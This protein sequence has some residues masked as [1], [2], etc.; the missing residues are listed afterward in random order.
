MET[1]PSLEAL[2][3]AGDSIGPFFLVRELGNGSFARVFLA[4]QTNLE[5]RLVVLK[6]ST[7]M[8]REP[9]LL[10]R[11]RHA[12]IVEIVS[13]ATVDDG[14]FHL[15]CMPF[16]GG[17]TLASVLADV[18][19][20]GRRPAAGNDLLDALD[21]VA[22]AEFPTGQTAG[23]AREILARQS[24]N[25]A[26]AWL[27]ARLAEALDYAFSRAVAHGDVKPSNII[28]SANASPL[29]LDFN[30]ARDASPAGLSH[31]SGDQ[32]GTFAYMA[33]ERLRAIETYEPGRHDASPVARSAG[34]GSEWRSSFGSSPS[35]QRVEGENQGSAH[36]SDIYSLGMVLLELLTGRHSEPALASPLPLPPTSAL[37]GEKAGRNERALSRDR[38]AK[39]LIRKSEAE[40]WGRIPPGLGAILQ[41]CLSPDPS[42]RYGRGLELAIDL[43]R[44]RSD[45]PPVYASE[46]FWGETIPRLMRRQ[47]RTL[48]TA[49]VAFVVIVVMGALALVNSHE[50]LRAIG[51]RKLRRIWDDP[52][53][54]AVRFQRLEAPRLLALDA[55]RIETAARALKEY[56]LLDPSDWRNREDVRSL[57]RLDRDD[58]E[59]WLVEQVYLYCRVLEARPDSPDH[60]RR[61]LDILGHVGGGAPVP[62][63]AGLERRLRVRLGMAEA[64]SSPAMAGQLAARESSWVNEYLL[65][66]MAECELPSDQG[67][68]TTAAARSTV[69][70][71]K[72]PGARDA[73][74]ATRLAAERALEHYHRFLELHPD[75]FWGHYR[76][77]A[78]AFGL[79]MRDRIARA[80]DHLDRC[81][82]RRPDNPTLH[83]HLAACLVKLDRNLEAQREVETAI[84]RAPD[85]AE[86]YR[87]R[88]NI[89][90]NLRQTNGLADD[91]RH[92]EL[93]AHRL[94]R[95]SWDAACDDYEQSRQPSAVRA[96]LFQGTFDLVARLGGPTTEPGRDGYVAGAEPGDFEARAGLATAFARP[97]NLTWPKSSSPSFSSSSPITSACA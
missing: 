17:A 7:R 19:A 61:A 54:R 63:F 90:S 49:A 96:S 28:L 25:Q 68:L 16:L 89:R 88:T 57:S 11:V 9:W 10:A 18:R 79:G 44:W 78:V 86:F 77:A 66:V 62:A 46:P 75:S 91:V 32:G 36:Q 52:E 1:K 34:L 5:N 83:H 3:N 26:V 69:G 67:Q 56:E 92:F 47:K 53:S 40:G 50:T 20:R 22:A 31:A 14:A 51:N 27:V 94:P 12:H 41:R 74:D 45:R 2:P 59:I 58:L 35:V 81:L 84:E 87:T 6:V 24:Y 48:A 21:G 97:G 29:L 39:D 73:G 43:D 15:I 60:W 30:L 38:S 82:K 55:S 64:I 42:G 70:S 13:H 8:T 93:L 72:G 65:G 76:A 95:T 37:G 71:I 23:P 33:P 80:A 85:V 4:E